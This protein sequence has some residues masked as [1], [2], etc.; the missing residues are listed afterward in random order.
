MFWGLFFFF[1][2]SVPGAKPASKNSVASTPKAWGGWVSEVWLALLTDSF[3]IPAVFIQAPAEI[4]EG[5]VTL[6]VHMLA[7]LGQRVPFRAIILDL[8]T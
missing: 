4:I 3:T 2:G 1:E 6:G 5:A 7:R 8:S